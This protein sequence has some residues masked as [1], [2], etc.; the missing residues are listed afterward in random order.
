MYY[1]RKLFISA[2]S[3]AEECEARWVRAD[4]PTTINW[5][6]VAGF[7][8]ATSR[9]NGWLHSLL[10]G[11]LNCNEDSFESFHALCWGPLSVASEL[12]QIVAL[13]FFQR[14]FTPTHP[15]QI[16]FLHSPSNSLVSVLLSVALKDILVICFLFFP[17]GGPQNTV[18]HWSQL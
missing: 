17:P 3:K 9:I 7:S 16:P 1:T 12:V 11:F 10:W 2:W 13:Q 14:T 8:G 5:T 15:Q 4:G 6:P 18:V